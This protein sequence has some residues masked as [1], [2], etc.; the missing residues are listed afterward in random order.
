MT[1]EPRHQLN[2]DEPAGEE[3]TASMQQSGSS[4]ND[5]IGPYRL[6][7]QIGEG[8]MGEVWLAEQS[9]PIKRR[10]AVKVIKRGM[11]TKSFIARFEAERQALAMMDHPTIARVFD[12]G[13]TADGRPFF[14]MEHIKGEPITNYCDTHRL[15]TRDRLELFTSVCTGVQH[16]HQK[17]II[18]RDL[19]PSNV[20]VAIQDGR[21]VPKI[22]DFGVAKALAQPLTE[23][24]M[25]T[26][27][28][29]MIGTPAY[30]SPEQAEMS[31]LNVDTRTDVYALG[32]L[33]YQLLTGDLPF[34]LVELRKAGYSEM[35]RVLREQEPPRPSTRVSTV[36]DHSVTTASNRRTEPSK[37]KHELRGDLDW[38]VMKA[39]EKDRNRRYDTANGLAMDI[40][41]YLADEPVAAGPPSNAYRVRKF[42]RR[43]RVGVAVAALLAVLLV[44]F[45]VTM[46]AQ[47]RRIAAERDRAELVSDFMI[48]LFYSSDTGETGGEEITARE[49]LDRGAE[50]I[51]SE[52]ADEPETQARLMLAMGDVYRNL[53]L[54]ENA[55]RLLEGALKRNVETTG[56]TSFET[57][58]TQMGLAWLLTHDA[59]YERAEEL[60]RRAIETLRTRNY[61]PVHLAGAYNNLVF[62]FL[63]RG[64]QLPEEAL[65]L[66]EEALEIQTEH[67]GDENPEVAGTLFHTAWAL[68]RTG[69][70]EECA[71]MYRR[72][73]AM[74]RRIFDGDH[75]ST[76]WTLNNLAHV[77]TALGNPEAGLELAIEAYEMNRRLYGELHPELGFNLEGQ[78]RAHQ[79]MNN[80]EAAL[81][82][83]REATAIDRQILPPDHPRLATRLNSLV[84]ALWNVGDISNARIYL[85]EAMKLR[86]ARSGSDHPSIATFLNNLG[87]LDLALGDVDSA[88]DR[89]QQAHEIVVAARGE[90]HHQNAYTIGNLAR[91]ARYRG[92]L[93]EAEALNLR[94]LEILAERDTHPM[95]GPLH[96]Q[97][98]EVYADQGRV[99][100]ALRESGLAVRLMSEDGR[101]VDWE[102]AVTRNIHGDCLSRAGRYDEAGPILEESTE[103]IL[104]TAPG[105]LFADE[106]SARLAAHQRRSQAR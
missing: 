19:K 52:L 6:L 1:D 9:S 57:A 84:V 4:A 88:A 63:R 93:E 10:V 83:I 53:G 15:S 77:E 26:E 35:M 13:E 27:L 2:D 73:L 70:A 30:M 58:R 106:A 51:E 69:Q 3:P 42:I 48:D 25:F 96:Q 82:A 71:A 60:Q 56:P 64:G 20:L 103:I 28:G 85:E 59:R 100:E 81:A 34:D 47:A 99:D 17:A 29:Q 5:T 76:G 98:A 50:R 92:N 65:P 67:L 91:V 24:T 102:F 105:D 32:V 55:T 40:G 49:I 18:H 14:V 101:G 23:K 94:A 95:I 12:A 43:H 79:A 74:R 72:T 97:L 104:T 75:A 90:D 8:G 45:G 54:Y 37:L 33:L 86:R 22:I 31:G 41:R 80:H 21:P 78:Y 89:L 61:D 39:I 44:A 66:L 68:C 16:A 36:R 87:E 46:A 7:Q 11:D 38:V 62:G